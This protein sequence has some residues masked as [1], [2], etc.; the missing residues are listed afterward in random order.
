V[1][2]WKSLS[3]KRLSEGAKIEKVRG[4]PFRKEGKK[5]RRSNQTFHR[6]FCIRHLTILERELMTGSS[7]SEP[8]KAVM[9]PAQAARNK[10]RLALLSSFNPTSPYRLLLQL[11]SVDSEA[12]ISSSA[13]LGRSW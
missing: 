2:W 1:R 8:N 11:G 10:E 13:D 3:S 9:Y 4:I 7:K 6:H 12:D 5:D